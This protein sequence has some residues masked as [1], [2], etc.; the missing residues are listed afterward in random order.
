MLVR[1]TF[2]RYEIPTHSDRGIQLGE[3]AL[4][5]G[6]D[7]GH[8]TPTAAIEAGRGARDTHNLRSARA[9]AWLGNLHGSS[10]NIN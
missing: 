6:V 4:P 9:R 7:A 1:C 3:V 10:P 8:A 5:C 2:R